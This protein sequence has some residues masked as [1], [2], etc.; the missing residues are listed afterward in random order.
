MDKTHPYWEGSQRGSIRIGSEAHKELFC[1]MLLDTF[2]PYK[3]AAIDWPEVDSDTLERLTS[4]P[5]WPLA[6]E[7]EGRTA[8]RMQ[9]LADET[10]DPLIKEALALNASEEWRHKEVIETMVRFYGIELA[11]EP[12]SPR[13]ERATWAYL[14]TGY[15]ECFDSFFAFGL[16]KLASDSGFFPP[17]LVEVF[18]PII[19]EEARHIL[20]FA[21]WVAY[22]R[23]RTSLWSLPAFTARCVT[24]FGAQAWDRLKLA[25]SHASDDNNISTQGYTSLGISLTPRA[26]M[27]MCLREN[28]RRMQHYD[29]R[30]L[31][32]QVVPRLVRVIRPLAG[33]A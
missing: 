13:P 16:F 12:V 10:T 23:V 20:F 2:E 18:E 32:P 14:R 15:G 21:N 8:L 9:V 30:L 24:A 5:F 6:V 11:D 27:D 26:F 19:Q 7:T 22:M 1:R 4:L 28:S 31:R 29:A 33:R 25:R 3:P 17:A